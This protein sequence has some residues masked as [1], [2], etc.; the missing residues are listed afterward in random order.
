MIF[1][2]WGLISKH[3][4]GL[5]PQ[6]LMVPVLTTWLLLDRLERILPASVEPTQIIT[7]RFPWNY[8]SECLVLVVNV[9]PFSVRWVWSYI[10]RHNFNNKHLCFYYHCEDIQH[11]CQADILYVFLQVSVKRLIDCNRHYTKDLFRAPTDCVQYFT[12]ISGSVKSYN[13]AGA[14]LLAGQ[15]YN[16]CI[17]TEKGYC[18]IQWKESSTTSPDPFGVGAAPTTAIGANGATPTACL[19][20][21]VNIPALSPDGIQKIPIPPGS[22]QAYQSQVCGV[23]FGIEGMGTISSALVCK[24]IKSIIYIIQLIYYSTITTICA[25]SL[26]NCSWYWPYYCCH[27]LQSGL[28]SGLYRFTYNDTRAFKICFSAPMLKLLVHRWRSE[29]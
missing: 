10:N 29:N 22:A 11:S 20:G 25:G 27:R 9:L 21:Y 14:Q 16:N 3:S 6:L 18:A 19:T 13:Y 12:G 28:Y 8:K 1:V 26:H 2:N 23:N 5:P 24:S 4:L 15:R 17:R 7:V